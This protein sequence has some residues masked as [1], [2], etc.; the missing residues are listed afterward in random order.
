MLVKFE[1]RLVG[2]YRNPE[3]RDLANNDFGQTKSL[4][5]SFWKI[6]SARKKQKRGFV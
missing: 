2:A 3:A 4:W 5:K 6:S 1:K